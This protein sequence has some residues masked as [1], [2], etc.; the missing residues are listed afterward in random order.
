ME[1][2]NMVKDIY[3]FPKNANDIGEPL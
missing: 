2:K 3:A 1:Y